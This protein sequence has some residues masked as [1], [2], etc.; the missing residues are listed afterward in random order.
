MSTRRYKDINLYSCIVLN[1]L[2]SATGVDLYQKDFEEKIE[3]ILEKP[4]G[5]LTKSEIM[6]EIRSNHNMTEKIL[7][8]LKE[9]GL[10]VIERDERSYRVYPTKEGLLHV[11]EFNKFYARIYAKQIEDHYRYVGLPSWYRKFKE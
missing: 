6:H 3:T 8:H 2:A 5:G 9:E 10:I 7:R 1:L 4:G 11:R